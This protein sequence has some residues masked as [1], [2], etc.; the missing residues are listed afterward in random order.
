MTLPR[1]QA[2]D[3]HT[4]GGSHC[5]SENVQAALEGAGSRVGIVNFG[6]HAFLH[7]HT[8]SHER[9]VLVLA[10]VVYIGGRVCCA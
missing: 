1:T 3:S 5:D 4:Q 2:T 9:G 6:V 10:P 8:D 7:A